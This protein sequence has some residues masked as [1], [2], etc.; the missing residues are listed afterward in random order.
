MTSVEVDKTGKL[1]L[2]DK[3]LTVDQPNGGS[4][5]NGRPQDAGVIVQRRVMAEKGYGREGLWQ[6]RFV[7]VHSDERIH[8]EHTFRE[9]EYRMAELI[10]EQQECTH[11]C[12]Q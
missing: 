5:V 8:G 12:G 6:R 10:R 7:E 9:E 3:T 11:S 1:S 2:I 4:D